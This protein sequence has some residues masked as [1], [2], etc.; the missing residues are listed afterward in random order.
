MLA[1]L[2]PKAY[3]T[4]VIIFRFPDERRQVRSE[5]GAPES[6][7]CLQAAKKLSGRA[8]PDRSFASL[9]HPL[10]EFEGLKSI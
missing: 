9:R 3:R 8:I 6:S 1:S 7:A 2:R 4:G 5:R 10:R